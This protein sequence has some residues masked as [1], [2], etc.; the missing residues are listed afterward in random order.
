MHESPSPFRKSYA[1]QLPTWQTRIYASP[2]T[3]R[4]RCTVDC[5]RSPLPGSRARLQRGEAC[6]VP[7]PLGFRK[8]GKGGV[9]ERRTA[10]STEESAARCRAV[11]WAAEMDGGADLSEA[12]ERQPGSCCSSKT[13]R[14][15][16]PAI[17][18]VVSW[19]R[20]KC[21]FMSLAKV[22]P[23]GGWPTQKVSLLFKILSSFSEDVLCLFFLARRVLMEGFTNC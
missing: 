12:R 21:G 8:P 7:T 20:R 6:H 17:S 14:S 15:Y 9:R 3:Y 5:A 1:K 16:P 22:R 11:A 2:L 23:T 4:W 19:R 10:R 18:F 13:S